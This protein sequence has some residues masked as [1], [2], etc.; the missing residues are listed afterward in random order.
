[1]I[2]T[3]EGGTTQVEVHFENFGFVCASYIATAQ[4]AIAN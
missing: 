4:G 1:M 2:L 3:P